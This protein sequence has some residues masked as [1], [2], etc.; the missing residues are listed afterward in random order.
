MFYF[1]SPINALYKTVGTWKNWQRY[2]LTFSFLILLILGWWLLSYR[3]LCHQINILSCDINQSSQVKLLCTKLHATIED[4]KQRY[5]DKQDTVNNN[6]NKKKQ[7]S[8]TVFS[9]LI[10]CVSSSSLQLLSICTNTLPL[11][12]N[13]DDKGI[14][15]NIRGKAEDLLTLLH[16]I[17]ADTYPLTISH[18]IINRVNDNTI[19]ATMTIIIDR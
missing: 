16:T 6:N 7:H 1:D 3:Y 13:D 4:E 19:A 8:D 15:L 11:A 2:S 5:N 10:D 18:C 9:W 14:S 17:D 12:N